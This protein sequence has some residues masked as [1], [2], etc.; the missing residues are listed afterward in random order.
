MRAPRGEEL[1]GLRDTHVEPLDPAASLGAVALHPQVAIAFALLRKDASDSGHDLRAV[2]AY[3][4]FDRQLAI[5]NAKARGERVL[6]DQH[7]A[8]LDARSLAPD[9]LVQAILRWSALPGCSR[10][11]W[12]TDL[13][14]VDAAVE[15]AGGPR[16][17]LSEC[18]DGGTYAALHRWLDR[19]IRAGK[20]HG[21]FRPYTGRYCAVSAEPWHLSFAPLSARCQAAFD[22]ESLRNTL[23][24]NALE[25]RA[26]VIEQLPEIL[27]R[28][29]ILAPK[30][31]PAKWRKL[32]SSA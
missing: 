26:Q 3:R 2:S 32:V 18:E 8:P 9:A 19:R 22:T 4:S 29:V 20:A 28:Y 30:L 16:L 23:E 10:H 24:S 6:L 17:L 27:E 13:D 11:H 14:V 7:E 12:G 5:W 15:C 25:L 31:Y 1:L 21:F